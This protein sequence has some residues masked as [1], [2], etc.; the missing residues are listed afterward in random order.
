LRNG[1][2]FDQ[3]G[4]KSRHLQDIPQAPQNRQ[5]RQSH[6]SIQT[7][8]DDGWLYNVRPIM[9]ERQ[10]ANTRKRAC[11]RRQAKSLIGSMREF[12]TRSYWL[13]AR[14][15]KARENLIATV[16]GCRAYSRLAL[17]SRIGAVER[18]PRPSTL[19]NYWGL[20]LGAAGLPVLFLSVLAG[21]HREQSPREIPPRFSIYRQRRNSSGGD[22]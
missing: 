7:P 3:I 22:P 17:A 1:F 13:Q 2:P 11:Q 16:P 15:Q 21:S 9:E 4:A 5:S 10:M 18:F 8:G 19:A 12:L 14:F 6:R 20:T